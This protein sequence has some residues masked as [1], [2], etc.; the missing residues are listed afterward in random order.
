MRVSAAM[1]ILTLSV[2]GN[3]GCNSHCLCCL[4]TPPPPG[5]WCV[6]HRVS[7]Q[8]VWDGNCING[9]MWSDCRELNPGHTHPMRAYYRCTTVRMS[10]LYNKRPLRVSLYRNKFNALRTV[11]TK[12]APYILCRNFCI[13]SSIGGWVEKSR[14][15]NEVFCFFP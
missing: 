11:N 15:K 3:G 6:F 1:R 9:L 13:L 5:M 14:W 2:K 7:I 4:R 8:G 12:C 10:L